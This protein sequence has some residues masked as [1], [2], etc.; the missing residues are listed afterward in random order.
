MFMK[1]VETKEMI[2]AGMQIIRGRIITM[3]AE[4]EILVGNDLEGL[5][6]S[7]DFLR[8]S[9]APPPKLNPG[10]SVLYIVDEMR[11]RGY[12]LGV[13]QKYLPEEEKSQNQLLSLDQMEPL[14][15]IQ[16]NAEEKIELR[17]GKSSLSMD[18]EGKVI[19]KG[20][21][22]VSRASGVN[23]IKGAAVKIN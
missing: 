7:C 16:F 11:E 8:T 2:L 18:R 10:D 20:D 23:K 22:L 6:L 12:V 9:D 5:S 21:Q 3:T 1:M 15:K 19:I 17:C 4:G 14:R 13:I